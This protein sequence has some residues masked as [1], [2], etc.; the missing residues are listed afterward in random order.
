MTIAATD[1]SSDLTS[2]VTITDTDDPSDSE[3][4][5]VNVIGGAKLSAPQTKN[6]GGA[7]DLPVHSPIVPEEITVQTITGSS[8]LNASS[9]FTALESI[10]EGL[11]QIVFVKNASGDAIAVAY[12]SADDITSGNFTI[13]SEKMAL[14]LIKLNPY[15][16]VLSADQEELVL[17]QARN[18]TDFPSLVADIENALINSPDNALDY[19]TYPYIYQK[20][21]RIGIEVIASYSG[22]SLSMR[23]AYASLA[24]PFT[25]K[26]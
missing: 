5:T 18:H 15:L 2:T 6:I 17:D 13:G 21:V 23:A 3:A 19:E 9:G 7:V 14:G 26:K 10:N 16:M 1:F 24:L 12:L 20:A 22:S 11:G 25:P 4:I 8:S